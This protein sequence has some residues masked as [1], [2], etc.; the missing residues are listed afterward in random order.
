[1]FTTQIIN[2]RQYS[3]SVLFW[4]HISLDLQAN[5][6]FQYFIR[7]FFSF[8]LICFSIFFSSRC[9]RS[10][11]IQHPF[12]INLVNCAKK[13]NDTIFVK[14]T[15]WFYFGISFRTHQIVTDSSTTAALASNDPSEKSMRFLH[16][17]WKFQWESLILPESPQNWSKF[18]AIQLSSLSTRNWLFLP[19]INQNVNADLQW[20]PTKRPISMT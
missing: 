16:H 8:F 5:R 12:F 11:T 4:T 2:R 17:L 1:M 13:C 3:F 9:C 19:R 20:L 18:S 7:L 6:L 14:K 10:S 15:H